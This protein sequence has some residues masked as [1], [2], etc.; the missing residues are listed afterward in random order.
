[1]VS[2]GTVMMV[3]MKLSIRT[4]IS[5]LVMAVL[6]FEEK[7]FLISLLMPTI[8]VVCVVLFCKQAIKGLFLAFFFSIL[9]N[10]RK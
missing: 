2:L 5:I 3:L 10:R 7:E 4:S 9:M 8:W 1:M 6:N